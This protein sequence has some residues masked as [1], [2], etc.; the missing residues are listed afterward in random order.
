MKKIEIVF[1]SLS[2]SAF[3]HT[4]IRNEMASKQNNSNEHQVIRETCEYMANFVK[5]RSDEGYANYI[6]V[7]IGYGGDGEEKLYDAIR[8]DGD[9]E[10]I[11]LDSLNRRLFETYAEYCDIAWWENET[12]AREY[13]T[14]NHYDDLLDDLYNDYEPDYLERVSVQAFCDE[15]TNEVVDYLT[16]NYPELLPAGEATLTSQA[17]EATETRL[18]EAENMLKKAQ[19]EIEK[20]KAENEKI[21]EQ[22]DRFFAKIQ[23]GDKAKDEL[24]Q[25]KDIFKRLV[26]ED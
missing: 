2:T 12:D 7:N 6:V 15:R 3:K 9:T 16:H 20:L 19:E 25:L 21:R 17:L 18:T 22:N 26:R 5:E 13:F 11:D 8:I 24:K 14:S 23:E 1:Q 4:T 10:G